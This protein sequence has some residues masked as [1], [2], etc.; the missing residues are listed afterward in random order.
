MQRPSH[1]LALQ[2]PTR[3]NVQGLLG[4]DAMIIHFVR[5]RSGR[6]VC[7]DRRRRLTRCARCEALVSACLP[8]CDIGCGLDKD[9]RIR[10]CDFRS[11]L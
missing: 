10:R 3:V 1:A 5:T 9:N 11:T 2:S 6:N 7:N 8:A 4:R